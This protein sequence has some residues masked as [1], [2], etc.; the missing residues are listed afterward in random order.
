MDRICGKLS[1]Y[2]IPETAI[3]TYGADIAKIDWRYIQN[4]IPKG[5]LVL[6]TAITPTPLGEGKTTVSIGLTDGLNSLGKKAIAALREPS[7]GP[8]FG[9]KGGATGGGQTE[10]HPVDKINLHFTGDFHAITSAHNLIASMI[11]QQLFFDLMDIDTNT[12]IWKRAL[13]MNDRHL[14]ELTIVIKAGIS[15][16]SGF[17]IT[18]SSEIMAIICLAENI[19]ELRKMLNRIVFA[20]NSKGEE[21]S[22]EQLDITDALLALL[23]DAFSPNAVLT[24]AG[25]LALVHGGPFANIAHGTNSLM[26]TKA[27]LS[28]AEFTITEAGFGSDLGAE[29]FFD[30]TAPKLGKQPD[31]VVLVT[32][33]RALKYHA[34]VE[35]CDIEKE[36][37]TA[38]K[39]GMANLAKHIANLQARQIPLVVTLNAFATDTAAEIAVLTSS[40]AAANIDFALNT[41]YLE[42]AKGATELGKRVIAAVESKMEYQKIADMQ[43]MLATKI[44]AIVKT[45]GATGVE[46]TKEAAVLLAELEKKAG[47]LPVCIAKTPEAFT[48]KVKD[49]GIPKP[50]IAE[51]RSL[52]LVAGAGMVIVFMGNIIDMPGLPKNPQAQKIKI[53]ADYK[54]IGVD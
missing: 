27:A 37:I 21:L 8:V 23:M 32:T 11:E 43:D 50:Y 9:R 31:C 16:K 52:K 54:I 20:K 14:R 39:K 51:I 46:Y 25:N 24:T 6:V 36:N 26:A 28:M 18:A 48:Q 41:A 40:L 34:Q 53:T 1:E 15:Y 10:I 38:L 5:K 4:S 17:Q 3:T 33:I 2:S 29:K 44:A 42:G 47:N 19:A 13:D 7:L 12:I 49:R 45:Y 30:I 22:V 35:L